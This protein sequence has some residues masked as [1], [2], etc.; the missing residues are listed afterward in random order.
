MAPE[1]DRR[2]RTG[3]PSS[4]KVAFWGTGVEW[5]DIKDVSS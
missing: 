5:Q 3:L 4:G 1:G 2:W